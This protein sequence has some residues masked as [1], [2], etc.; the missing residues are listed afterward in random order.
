[1]YKQ[2]HRTYIAG[3]SSSRRNKNMVSSAKPMLL[4]LRFPPQ[5][6]KSLGDFWRSFILFTLSLAWWIIQRFLSLQYRKFHGQIIEALLWPSKLTSP[7]LL[8]LL[9][10]GIQANSRL[11]SLPSFGEALETVH[12]IVEI[13]ATNAWW[14]HNGFSID[15]I[16]RTFSCIVIHYA[17]NTACSNC[18]RYKTIINC[19]FMLGSP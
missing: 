12:T 9:L 17:S 18:V 14:Y 16:F 11:Y 6:E 2:Q 1:M 13:S 10:S 19:M 7:S 3:F 5:V 8:S 15:Q 4:L